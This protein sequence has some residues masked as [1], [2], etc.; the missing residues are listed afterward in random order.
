MKDIIRNYHKKNILNGTVR[1][2][3]SRSLQ[4]LYLASHIQCIL[5]WLVTNSSMYQFE[6]SNKHWIETDNTKCWRDP[7]VNQLHL[8]FKQ[9]SRNC[10][11]L[12]FPIYP[13]NWTERVNIWFVKVESKATVLKASIGYRISAELNHPNGQS[14]FTVITL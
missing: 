13:Q 1:I 10:H 7:N 4:N 9:K 12:Q 11:V 8:P 2:L 6:I 3:A 5:K 14:R